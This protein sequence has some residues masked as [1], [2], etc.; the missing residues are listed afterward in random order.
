M[1][2]YYHS[3]HVKKN[4]FYKSLYIVTLLF[5]KINILAQLTIPSGNAFT[6][7]SNRPLGAF[8][9]YDN[10]ISVYRATE[11][12]ITNGSTITG[13]RYFVQTTGIPVNVP[14]SIA[15]SNVTASGFSPAFL[16]ATVVNMTNVYNGT[17]LASDIAA[18]KWVTI[19][20]TTPFVYTGN[21]LQIITSSYIGDSA[22]QGTTDKTFRWHTATDQSQI[23]FSNIA[24][25]YPAHGTVLDAKPNIQILYDTPGA[26]GTLQLDYAATTMLENR[27]QVISVNRSGG[28]TGAVSVNYATSDGTA[29]AGTDY[30]ATSGTLNWADGDM[31]PKSFT[32]TTLPDFIVDDGKTINITLSN[33]TGA[34]IVGT[35][36]STITVTDVLPPMQGTYTVGVG[37][38]YTSLTN[39]GGIFQAINQRVD[40]VSGPI[41]INII[42]NL[43]G[44]AATYGLNEIVGNHAVLIRPFGGPRS[45]TGA[46]FNSDP[47]IRFL[48]TDNVT[49]DGSTIGATVGS[50]LM[51]GDATLRELT[52]TNTSTNANGAAVGFIS[53][54]G[55]CKNSTVKNV[56]ISG[57]T[58]TG[59]GYGIAFGGAPGVTGIDND[60]IKVENCA[61]KKLR[62]GIISRGE[63]L[64]N[65]NIG[66]VITQN[67]L[68][69]TGTDRISVNGIYMTGVESCNKLQ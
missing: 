13:I 30:N 24:D 51:G 35:A 32:V 64:A 17:I 16:G 1:K 42:S 43:T 59:N 53:G 50:C 6:T 69:T 48:G 40:G 23:W 27:A 3:L 28:S 36:A 15:M 67:D 2:N 62:V 66:T 4:Y 21:N 22:G 55:G 46:S 57:A 18:G 11:M 8:Y 44:E 12:N 34:P 20:L 56:I 5:C 7:T 58:S 10:T 54:T 37:G 41:T 25:T 60:N 39:A 49:I 52:I 9:K 45:I 47:M 19:P 61:I 14:V 33:P 63:S 65:Q 68:S 38:N 26:T 31:A 29:I